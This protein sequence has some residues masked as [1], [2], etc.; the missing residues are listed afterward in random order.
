MPLPFLTDLFKKRSLEMY[1]RKNIYLIHNTE[2]PLGEK[3]A[4]HSSILAW[5]ISWTDE[6]VGLQSMR[7]QRVGHN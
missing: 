2:D 3:M 1:L 5:I 7:S 6:P 4:T